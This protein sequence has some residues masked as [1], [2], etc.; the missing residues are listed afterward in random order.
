MVTLL[1][2]MAA[3]EGTGRSSS[4]EVRGY[5]WEWTQPPLRSNKL[6]VWV[7]V[8]PRVPCVVKSCPLSGTPFPIVK[9]Q[10]LEGQAP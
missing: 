8:L 1:I 3:L 9:C 10:V 6:P 2:M 4:R 5:T 7:P